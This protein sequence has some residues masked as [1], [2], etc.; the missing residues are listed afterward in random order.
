MRMKDIDS[1]GREREKGRERERQK[2]RVS[3]ERSEA[4]THHRRKTHRASCS[5][6]PYAM[7]GKAR[8][9]LSHFLSAR[10]RAGSWTEFLKRYHPIIIFF[11][12]TFLL[13]SCPAETSWK[14]QYSQWKI[15]KDCSRLL[16]DSHASKR[17][18]P[19]P[20]VIMGT[21]VPHHFYMKFK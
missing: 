11:V 14:L 7:R 2:K 21:D 19:T 5:L 20:W 13:H 8:R 3:G 16:R 9:P 1:R 4:C 12:H 6:C 15:S 17:A 10:C 18:H